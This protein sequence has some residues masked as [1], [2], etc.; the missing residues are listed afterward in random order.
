M[1]DVAPGYVA[2]GRVLAPW[3]VRGHLK[4]E[5]LADQPRYLSPGRRVT[6]AGQTFTIE[7]AQRR[8][9]LLHLKLA[10]IDD[11]DA[12][13]ALRG[14]YLL[15]AEADLAP[16]PEGEYYR[17]QLI[18]LAVRGSDGQPLGRVRSVLSTP[19]N[20]VLVVDGQL[21]EIL[22]PAID[23]IVKEIDLQTGAMTIEVVPGLLPARNPR[24][25]HR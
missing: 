22:I 14:R 17:F 10:G 23:D 19:G 7:R 24:K 25:R 13:A 2:V 12:A 6:V 15:I 5:P 21:G 16:L 4:V 18:G 9:H 1:D 20:D 3:G 8:Q 11:R